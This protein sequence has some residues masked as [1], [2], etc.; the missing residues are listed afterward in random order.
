MPKDYDV[1]IAEDKAHAKTLDDNKEFAALVKSFD[2]ASKEIKKYEEAI[3]KWKE[4]RDAIEEQIEELTRVCGTCRR[5]DQIRPVGRD[6]FN[7]S[8][9][10][11]EM[12]G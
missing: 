1:L 5:S 8:H 7:C 12:R 11:D 9:C 4:H 6:R 10:I 2:D 3:Q